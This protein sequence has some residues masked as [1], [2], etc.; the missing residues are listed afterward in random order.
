M[1]TKYRPAGSLVT[2]TVVTLAAFGM[3]REKRI[4]N[5]S[6]ILASFKVLPS[7]LKAL[8]VYSAAC[9]PSFR[10]NAGYFARLAKKLA[11][12]VCRWRRA[13]CTG[14]DDTSLRKAYSGCFFSTVSME[15]VS[16]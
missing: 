8:T 15:D 5:G 11:K 6:F 9:T 3:V 7:H 1:E 13:C 14:T 10:L 4:F 12:A 2:V 16:W